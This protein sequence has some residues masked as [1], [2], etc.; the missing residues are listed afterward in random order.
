[1]GEGHSCRFLPANRCKSLL[2][3]GEAGAAGGLQNQEPGVEALGRVPAPRFWG[4]QGQWMSR[5]ACTYL[6]LQEPARTTATKWGQRRTSA[7]EEG[8]SLTPAHAKQAPGLP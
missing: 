8:C 1:M 3:P 6:T 4:W 5:G 2:G 7:C